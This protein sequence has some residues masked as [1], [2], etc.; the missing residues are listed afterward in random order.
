V[1]FVQG[2]VLLEVELNAIHPVGHYVVD[3][4]QFGYALFQRSRGQRRH[5]FHGE[6]RNVIIRRDRAADPILLD[7]SAGNA[8]GS[9]LDLPYGYSVLDVHAAR[10]QVLHPRRQPHVI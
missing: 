2:D 9:N 4:S 8:G 6:R 3:T 5:D 7:R 10:R 1:A